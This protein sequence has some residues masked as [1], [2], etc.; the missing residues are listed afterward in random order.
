MQKSKTYN[1]NNANFTFI[2]FLEKCVNNYQ[3]VFLSS[4]NNS[5]NLRCMVN[6]I[7]IF[8]FAIALKKHFCVKIN[9]LLVS[10]F[11]VCKTQAKI[12]HRISWRFPHTPP[13]FQNYLLWPDNP[14]KSPKRTLA[15]HCPK[16]TVEYTLNIL[17]PLPPNLYHKLQNNCNCNCNYF[18]VYVHTINSEWYCRIKL[19]S[20]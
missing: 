13:T 10:K 4:H 16:N 14:R 6:K 1:A 8:R 12:K 9:F 2:Y 11:L 5:K 3:C 18:L 7:A 15:P 19:C 17:S 20:H